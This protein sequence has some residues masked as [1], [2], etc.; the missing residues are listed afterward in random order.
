MRDANNE[1]VCKTGFER[2]GNTCLE[3]CGSN[4]VRDANNECVCKT[5]FERLDDGDCSDINTFFLDRDVEFELNFQVNM[6]NKEV[7]PDGVHL[8][9]IM[10]TNILYTG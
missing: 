6:R 10:D 4:E 1:C 3:P 7:S 8:V 9:V 5:G 2:I